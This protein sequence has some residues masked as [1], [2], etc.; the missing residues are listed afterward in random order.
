MMGEY[1][2]DSTKPGP[3]LLTAI[4]TVSTLPDTFG[5]K[6]AIAEIRLHPNGK[7]LYVGNRGHNSIAI[8]QVDQDDGTLVRIG[9]Q[10]SFGSFPRHYNFDNTGGFLLVGNHAS[11]TIV[12]FRI[13]SDGL[14]ELADRMG[15][16]PSIVWVTA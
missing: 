12:A 16:L 4:Q 15:N 2:G 14:L 6:S 1:M 3:S 5:S 9:I 7:F 10:D 13:G 11:D 8:F